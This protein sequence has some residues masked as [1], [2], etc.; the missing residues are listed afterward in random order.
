MFLLL[1]FVLILLNLKLTVL[2]IVPST[3]ILIVPRRCDGF[4]EAVSSPHVP[5]SGR[6]TFSESAPSNNTGSTE[7]IPEQTLEFSQND[8][9]ST[10]YNQHF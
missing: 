7:V 3:P 5:T 6:F 4:G 2:G 10:F 9:N 1:Q 8:D